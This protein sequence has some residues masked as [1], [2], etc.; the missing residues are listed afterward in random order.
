MTEVLRVA[1]VA[2]EAS[3]LARHGGRADIVAA[4]ARSL[5]RRGHQVTLFLPAYRDLT[6]PEGTADPTAPKVAP[7][8]GTDVDE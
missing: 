6:F 4:V 2:T 8:A 5:A 7:P 3:P 1:L